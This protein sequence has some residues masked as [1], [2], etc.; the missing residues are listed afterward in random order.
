MLPSMEELKGQERLE[1]KPCWGNGHLLS[2]QE[3]EL[4]G[5]KLEQ[6]N[7]G[8]QED[9]RIPGYFFFFWRGG[10]WEGRFTCQA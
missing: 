7:V 10:K 4:G 8:C 5:C 1:S 3:G 9:L 2:G 6:V